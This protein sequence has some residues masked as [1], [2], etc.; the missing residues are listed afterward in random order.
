MIL[1]YQFTIF[2]FRNGRILPRFQ[3]DDVLLSRTAADW[4]CPAALLF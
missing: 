4:I 1:F 3:L 2:L